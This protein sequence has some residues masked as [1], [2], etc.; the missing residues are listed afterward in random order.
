MLMPRQI[1]ESS[2]VGAIGSKG[3]IYPFSRRLPLVTKPDDAHPEAVPTK[4]TS[5]E[6]PAFND[7]DLQLPN[8]TEA[9]SKES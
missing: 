9:V 6:G 5:E 4:V 1:L 7:Q 2:S 8:S 3:E